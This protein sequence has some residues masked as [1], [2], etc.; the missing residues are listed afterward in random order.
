ML[1]MNPYVKRFASGRVRMRVQFKKDLVVEYI[2]DNIN[3]PQPLSSIVKENDNVQRGGLYDDNASANS[4][5]L[6]ATSLLD[7]TESWES[8]SSCSEVESVK[9]LDPPSM[10]SYS[11][12][13]QH[14]AMDIIH[15]P[16]DP[17]TKTVDHRSSIAIDSIHKSRDPPTIIV[18]H[19]PRNLP[20]IMNE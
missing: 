2:Y 5:Q 19:K 18:D 15:K 9:I 3:D 17:P 4:K 12:Y 13:H 6:V 7:E 14:R 20:I 1:S 10:H 16:K 8:T 11:T